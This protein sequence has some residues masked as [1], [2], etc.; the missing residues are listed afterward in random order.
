M[1][2]YSVYRFL[3]VF[4]MDMLRPEDEEVLEELLDEGQFD[5]DT[6]QRYVRQCEQEGVSFDLFDSERPFLQTRYRA[7]WEIQNR[8]PHWITLSQM[9]TTTSISI[10]SGRR[11]LTRPAKRCG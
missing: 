10:T 5:W 9:G 11:S 1:V 7:D 8:S 3:I 4:L 6:I 2:E